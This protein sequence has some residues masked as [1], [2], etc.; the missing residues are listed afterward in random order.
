MWHH[1]WLWLVLT[2]YSSLQKS[3]WC[4]VGYMASSVTVDSIDTTFFTSARPVMGLWS[5]DIISDCSQCWHYIYHVS[6]ASDALVLIWRYQ[7]LCGQYW[8]CV[9][10]ER[11]E[12][13]IVAH[14]TSVKVVCTRTI[15]LASV[16]C[17]T[18]DIIMVSTG[19]VPL[20]Q[21]SEWCV[22]TLWHHQ[23]L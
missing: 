16:R 2:L 23:W 3:Q 6:K 8:H 17:C 4:I 11:S 19:T 7:W 22:V 14:V 12:P 21:W 9:S 5:C 20:R 13:Y 15:F 10:Q 18:Y 1:R